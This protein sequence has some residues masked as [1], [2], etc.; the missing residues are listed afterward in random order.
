MAINASP[1]EVV[2]VTQHY[3][4]EPIGSAPYCADL[5]E[6]MAKQGWRASVLTG[7]PQ[8]P[9]PDMFAGEPQGWLTRQRMAGVD[10]LRLGTWVPRRRSTAARILC[11][12]VFLLGG[13]LALALRRV[14]RRQLV[15]SVCP[16][17]LAVALGVALKR[18]GGR[19]VAIV[20]DI[21]SGLAE[22]LGMVGGRLVR[23]IRLCERLVLNRLDMVSVLTPEMAA[24]LRALGVKA[25][26][27]IVPIWVDTDIIR[28]VAVDSGGRL[29]VLYSG[30]F[31]RKQGL[32]QIISMAAELQ[33]RRPEL[34]ILLRGG[35][36]RRRELALEIERRGLKNVRIAE[37]LP[38][39]ALSLGLAMGDVHLVPQDP[40]AADSAIPSKIFNIMA[41]ARPFVATAN[42]G[43]S[44]W[45]MQDSSGAFL[46]VP[47]NQPGALAEAVMR[48]AD[49]DRLRAELGAKGRRFVEQ[50]FA[51]EAVLGGFRSLVHDL[52]AA[53]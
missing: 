29:T 9:H 3:R 25:P 4:P 21:Q 41:A 39:E 50:H 35:G 5:A 11:E 42:P 37:L 24:R 32:D 18:R 8:Y 46:C 19:H 28:P 34:E 47:P 12:I 2:L 48:L 17:I 51:K 10:V 38:P 53:R 23:A 27:E 26:I 15:I 31:G 13:L 7:R 45:R 43:S 36:S 49:D 33:A 44:L 1:A 22:G 52:L 6:W 14:E 40:Q 16:S 20:H 30:N